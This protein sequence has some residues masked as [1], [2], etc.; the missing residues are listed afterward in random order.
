MIRILQLS[1]IHFHNQA[2]DDDDFAQMRVMF[3]KDIQKQCAKKSIDRIIVCGDI[4]FSAKKEQ[5]LEAELFLDELKKVTNCGVVRVVPGNHDLDRSKYENLKEA[6]RDTALTDES[7]LAK[8]RNS[9]PLVIKALYAQFANYLDFSYRYVQLASSIAN[10]VSIDLSLSG[11]KKKDLVFQSIDKF[12]WEDVIA[13]ENGYTVT[14]YGVNT[15]LLSSKK[16]DV[17]EGQPPRPQWFPKQMWNITRDPDSQINLLMGHHP[18]SHIAN[19][20]SIKNKISSRVNVQFYGH[21]HKQSYEIGNSL[22]IQSGAFMPDEATKNP[23]EYFPVYNIIELSVNNST[24]HVQ[25]I[26]RKWDGED[27]VDLTVGNDTFDLPL[28]RD[29]EGDSNQQSQAA[30]HTINNETIKIWNI[31]LN[32]L[33]RKE[34]IDIILRLYPDN[35]RF[36]LLSRSK[37][38]RDWNLLLTLFYGEL[39]KENRFDL[40]YKEMEELFQVSHRQPIN[41]NRGVL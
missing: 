14:L 30:V 36:L 33:V 37:S 24:L 6:I 19:G 20:E 10:K 9:E 4:A 2:S 23:T 13:I 27:F 21:V 35:Y 28:K 5:Y 25:I 7:F 12:Y 29:R 8:C 41:P 17:K 38:D 15:A 1:D 11:K 34:K 40:L 18:Y 3:P 22:I 39:R 26:S 32:K 16:D 31:Y